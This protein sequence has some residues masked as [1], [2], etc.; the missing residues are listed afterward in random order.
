M[1][2]SELP[3]ADL[4][5]RLMADGV[6]FRTGTFTACLRTRLDR[7]ADSF[8]L[9]YSDYPLVDGPFADF[10]VELAPPRGLRRWFRPQVDF[11]ADG[12]APF[13]A[14]PASQA[15]PMFEWG[16]NW[17]VSSHAHHYLIIHAA[18]IEKNGHAAILPAPPGSGKSTLC[19]ALIHHGWRLLSDELTLIRRD[20]GALVPLPRPVSLKNAS[21]DVIKRYV[22]HA[23]FSPSVMDTVKGTVAQMKAPSRSIECADQ[24][25]RPGWIVFP[26]YE[27][28]AALSL[29][30]VPRSRAFMRVADNA[31]NYTRLGAAGFE[32][33]RGVVAHSD[34]YDFRYSRLDEAI[35]A[36]DQLASQAGAR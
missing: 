6:Y 16:L 3:D 17:C 33:L 34:C 10:H 23:T 21:I 32:A 14:L 22:P 27:A 18:V 25:A 4:R 13:A 19:A 26:R 24:V 12:H 31:F 30:P 2:I 9:L 7:V 35:A 8:G 1:K 36:F 20:D 11:I 15:F 28:N 29:A 5:L